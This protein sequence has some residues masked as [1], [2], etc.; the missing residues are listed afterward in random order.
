MPEDYETVEGILGIVDE[1]LQLINHVL[2]VGVVHGK[3]NA[4][5]RGA[6]Q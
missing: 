6:R 2:M 5:A 1:S 4:L 3:I